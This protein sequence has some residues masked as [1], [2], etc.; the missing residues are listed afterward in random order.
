MYHH[1]QVTRVVKRQIT[2]RKRDEDETIQLTATSFKRRKSQKRS[3]FLRRKMKSKEQAAKN[4]LHDH[5]KSE[6]EE[7]Q[8]FLCILVISWIIFLGTVLLIL[9]PILKQAVSTDQGIPQNL[10]ANPNTTLEPTPLTSCLPSPM[11]VAAPTIKLNIW[12]QEYV[13]FH[14]EVTSHF[15]LHGKPPSGSK[16][17][18]YVAP[19]TSNV[20]L[21]SEISAIQ[22]SLVSLFAVCVAHRIA[23]YIDWPLA[24]EIFEFPSLSLYLN[25]TQHFE[26]G[27]VWEDPLRD[28]LLPS[29]V[30]T[31]L[32][33][34]ITFIRTQQFAL[35]SFL[36]EQF[37]STR[38]SLKSKFISPQNAYHVLHSLLFRPIEP[39]SHSLRPLIS[40]MSQTVSFFLQFPE[41]TTE[42]RL[43]K[44]LRV[45]SCAKHV[46]RSM[47]MVGKPITWV[48][49]SES[50]DIKT[51]LKKEFKD[52][53]IVVLQENKSAEENPIVSEQWN[54]GKIFAGSFCDYFIFSNDDAD[55]VALQSS[56]L[57]DNIYRV[58]DGNADHLNPCQLQRAES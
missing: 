34:N 35:Y 1:P 30:D 20:I 10:E 38:E 46:E 53:D 56:S 43:K 26:G 13:Q 48:L 17:M 2:P 57:L 6:N 44:A 7:R 12:Q 8:Q 52:V 22:R 49:T 11:P 5:E 40:K 15:R 50:E 51:I 55:D 21:H 16:M 39:V 28:E 41:K 36:S 54:I 24:N 25:H 47:E 58:V 14:S 18:V 3:P 9:G 31:V 45:A 33:Q 42:H 27:L 29:F 32:I 37:H 23:F 19:Q 4:L